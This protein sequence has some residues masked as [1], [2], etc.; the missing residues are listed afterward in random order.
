MSWTVVTVVKYYCTSYGTIL[1]KAIPSKYSQ[2]YTLHKFTRRVV[3]NCHNALSTYMI[4]FE[5]YFILPVMPSCGD[6]HDAG[7]TY[8][9][10][11]S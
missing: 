2:E 6:L 10:I 5:S 7:L 8:E 1:D 9:Q 3:S 11:Y 4:F